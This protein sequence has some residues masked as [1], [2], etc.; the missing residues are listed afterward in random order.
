MGSKC[1]F[2]LGDAKKVVYEVSNE[3]GDELEAPKVLDVAKRQF[4]VFWIK[5]TKFLN[6]KTWKYLNK[7][8]YFGGKKYEN[9]KFI[10]L[11]LQRTWLIN[12][13][14]YYLFNKNN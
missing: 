12:V 14:N 4:H 9:I 5:N 3:S 6:K 8:M 13:R 11:D 10:W 1:R 2:L 7:I